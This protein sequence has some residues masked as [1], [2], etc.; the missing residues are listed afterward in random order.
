MAFIIW[1][2]SP[3]TSA[4]ISTSTATSELTP[5]NALALPRTLTR[6]R[7]PQIVSVPHTE[8][9]VTEDVP[10]RPIPGQDC[11]LVVL[12]EGRY[13]VNR[14]TRAQRSVSS[15]SAALYL[16]AD[17]PPGTREVRAGAKGFRTWVG[18]VTVST[19]NS[20]RV[21]LRLQLR[22]VEQVVEASDRLLAHP[23]S[24][25]RTDRMSTAGVSGCCGP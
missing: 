24:R 3:R 10:R 4:A 6:D 14:E 19:G 5:V 17:L 18:S 23:E 21:D 12:R 13:I 16:I 22:I 7:H 1:T 15:D 11:K 25:A 20:T 2:S 8:V 9:G